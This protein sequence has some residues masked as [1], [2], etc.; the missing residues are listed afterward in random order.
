ME[1]STIGLPG[2]LDSD[3]ADQIPLSS[4]PGPTGYA[5]LTNTGTGEA[6]GMMLSE[7]IVSFREP[8]RGSMFPP[9]A[10]LDEADIML[11]G[12][13]TPNFISG[14][15]LTDDDLTIVNFV[16]RGDIGQGG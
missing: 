15:T 6:N 14:K 1:E 5:G 10:A 12:R 3:L 8:A 11:G 16:R 2:L 9:N 4:S 13:N 7:A